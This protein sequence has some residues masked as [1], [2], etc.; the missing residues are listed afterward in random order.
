MTLRS[1]AW[2]RANTFAHTDFP[3]ERLAA[4]RG[5][6]V[7]VCLPARAE[8]RTIIEALALNVPDEA[9]RE[10]F[11]RGATLQIPALRPPTPL[12]EAKQAL[13]GLT[14]REREVARLVAQGKS[15][16]ALADELFLSERTIGKH[17]ERIM[18]KLDF[19]SRAQIAAW[20][21]E[22]GLGKHSD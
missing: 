10:Q 8:A 14:A 12:Q 7:S 3:P 1:R 21:I 6:T 15:N 18:T 5:C 16:R 19:N 20:A 17:I 22:K 11:L 9:L 2:D 4:E 13:G